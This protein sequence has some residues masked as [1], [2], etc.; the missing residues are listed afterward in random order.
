MVYKGTVGGGTASAGHVTTLPATATAADKISIGDT[1]KVSVAG[2][3]GGISAQKGDLLIATAA[4]ENADGYIVGPITWTMIASDEQADTQYTVSVAN[5]KITLTDNTDDKNAQ[6][7]EVAG[8]TALTASTSGSV[9]NGNAKI[10]IN[11]DASGVTA[12]SYGL[13]ADATPT[14]GATFNVP[15]VT[16]NAQGHVTS[17]SNHTI[18][19]PASDDTTYTLAGDNTEKSITLTDN[20]SNKKGR[21]RFAAGTAMTVSMVDHAAETGVSGA[22]KTVTV[23]H[24]NVT[25]TANDGKTTNANQ[26][27]Y[28]ATFTAVTGVVADAQGHVSEVSKTTFKLPEEQLYTLKTDTT[29]KKVS[30]MKNAEDTVGAMTFSSSYTSVNGGVQISVTDSSTKQNAA[31][32]VIDL[33]W[34]TF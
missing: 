15:Y 17:A 2:T 13:A 22:N 19:I 33:V 30:L 8:G 11:H 3:Y 20:D 12:G 28:G 25:K 27:A 34:G 16:V 18:K 24:A 29:N 10:T 5:N 4:S 23:T 26:S 1:Y 6:S 7:I 21:V 9:A 31:N 32:V 14:Y